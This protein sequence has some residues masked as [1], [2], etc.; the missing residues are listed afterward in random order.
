M[1][2]ASNSLGTAGFG[3]DIRADHSSLDSSN[4]PITLGGFGGGNSPKLPSRLIQPRTQEVAYY[5]GVP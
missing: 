4:G 1:A 2:K 5:T 3:L